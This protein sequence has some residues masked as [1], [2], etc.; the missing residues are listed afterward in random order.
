M[1]PPRSCPVACARGP[2]RLQ[3]IVSI[4]YYE[5]DSRKEGGAYITVT[6]AVKK[7]D[8]I[9]REVVLADRRSIR[10][11]DILEIDSTFFRT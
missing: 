6:G 10:I 3:A 2:E 11:D 8:P 5:P 7:V 4:T 9:Q 1:L